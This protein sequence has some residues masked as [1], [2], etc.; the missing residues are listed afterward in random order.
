MYYIQRGRELFAL[1]I[2]LC[3]SLHLSLEKRREALLPF[4]LCP[5]VHLFDSCLKEM[6]KNKN[7][8]NNNNF[9]VCRPRLLAVKR[10]EALSHFFRPSIFFLVSCLKEMKKNKNNNNFAICRPRLLAVKNIVIIVLG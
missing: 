10:D 3:V 4:S 5:S 2:P 9:A 1:R 7:K 8:N 6:K